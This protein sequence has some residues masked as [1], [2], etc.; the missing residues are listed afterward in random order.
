MIAS[1][2]LATCL[3]AAPTAPAAAPA[4]KAPPAA[5]PAAQSA[6]AAKAVAPAPSAAELAKAPKGLVVIPTKQGKLE[7][8]HKAHAKTACA[9]CHKGQAEPARFG[10]KGKAA[11]HQFCVDCHKAE[12]QGPQKCSACHQRPGKV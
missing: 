4:P 6:P 9:A 12:Q 5:K 2:L 10:L 3:L 7:F 11:A 8:S 1:L